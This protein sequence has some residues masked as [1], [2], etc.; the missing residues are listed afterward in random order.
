MLSYER[1]SH[2][3]EQTSSIS[4]LRGAPLIRPD[5]IADTR[6]K[7]GQ[8]RDVEPLEAEYLGTW[9]SGPAEQHRLR[10]A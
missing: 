6:L 2:G 9:V 8:A 4:P 3:S 5:L 1:R 7:A 10:D